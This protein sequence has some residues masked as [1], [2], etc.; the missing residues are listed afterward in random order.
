[1]TITLRV[2]I[3]VR[4]LTEGF[5][6]SLKEGLGLGS[7]L[8]IFHNQIVAKINKGIHIIFYKSSEMK[9]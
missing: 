9:F 5:S 6:R 7:L 1:M 8:P 4:Y 2:R 3:R